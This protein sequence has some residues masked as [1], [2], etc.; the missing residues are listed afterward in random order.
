[1]AVTIPPWRPP[2]APGA[3]LNDQ[4]SIK[5]QLETVAAAS[6]E[7]PIVYG[8]CMI[9]GRIFAATY[10]GGV[11]YVGALFCIGEIDSYVN[12][13]LND[14]APVTGVTVTYYTGT[15]SQTADATLAA[16]ISGYT[17]TLIVSTAQGSVGVAYVVFTYTDSHYSGLPSIKARIKGRKVYGT[18][19]NLIPYS[20]DITGAGWA[21]TADTGRTANATTAPDGA[22]TA[23]KLTESTTTSAAHYANSPS[24]S[25]LSDYAAVV[26]SV[27]LKAAERTFARVIGVTK[28]PGTAFVTV[29]LST[30]LITSTSGA[31]LLDAG[32]DAVGNG[33]HRVWIAYTTNTGASA[34]RGRVQL[35]QSATTGTYAGTIGNGI[36]VWGAQF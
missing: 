6:T 8:E 22:A 16:S 3:T 30:G 34:P 17:D 32:S 11:W 24:V 12:L 36:Y 9:G 4:R 13:Y 2:V 18:S 7:I 15:T 1:M 35:M 27:Y 10:T 20:E 14:A 26:F 33:W 19:A 5:Q 29:D 31:D 28:V 25:G 21:V 23:D